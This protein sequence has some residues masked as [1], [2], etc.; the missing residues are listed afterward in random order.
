V[1]LADIGRSAM[2]VAGAVVS[3]PV[4]ASV[5]VAAIPPASSSRARQDGDHHATA[6]AY[7]FLDG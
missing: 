6:E 7:P 1:I 5:V 3:A 4:P 2:V